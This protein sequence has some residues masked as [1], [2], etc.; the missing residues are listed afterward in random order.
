ML[1]RKYCTVYDAFK[2]VLIKNGNEFGFRLRD[3]CAVA[4]L[5]F[6]E[7]KKKVN[8]DCIKHFFRKEGCIYYYSS[9]RIRGTVYDAIDELNDY[10]IDSKAMVYLTDILPD[11]LCCR[12]DSIAII[13]KIKDVIADAQAYERNTTS[14]RKFF[15]R[16]FQKN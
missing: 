13:S 3:I 2:K 4:E 16:L 8:P 11:C 12:D 10:W 9:Q 15:D 7:V 1:Q 6:D 14:L 5:D